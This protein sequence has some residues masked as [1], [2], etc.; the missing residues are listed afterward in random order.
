MI[1]HKR[2]EKIAKSRSLILVTIFMITGIY[3]LVA[4][5]AATN[6]VNLQPENGNI[7]GNAMM[8]NDNSASNNKSLMFG[9]MPTTSVF[10]RND[11]P[12]YKTQPT[13]P[14][15]QLDL[16]KNISGQTPDFS[17]F[18]YNGG[19]PSRN[20]GQFRSICVISHISKDDPI[21][22]PNQPGAAH[23][24]MFYGNTD[25]NAYSTPDS[26]LNSGGS[27]CDGQEANRTSYWFPVMLDSN[28]KTR[29]P[30]NMILYYKNEGINMPAEGFTAIPGGVKM[31]AGNGKAT[32][33]QPHDYNDGF[34]CGGGLF[35]NPTSD[36]I[37]ICSKPNVLS[38]KILFPRCWDGL[39]IDMTSQPFVAHVVYPSGYHS[40]TCDAGHPKVLAEIS[41]LFEWELANGE[42]T[43]GWYL[44]SDITNHSTGAHLPGGTTR[45]GDYMAGW[46]KSVVDSW[47]KDCMNTEWNC[48]TD[49]L[50]NQPNKPINVGGQYASL[51][52]TD[53]DMFD[54]KGPQ[55]LDIPH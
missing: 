28:G 7:I 10:Y 29:L 42:T 24:H 48:Q 54:D 17:F 30:N 14:S 51:K 4:S 45:H 53:F 25:T 37:P 26:I 44:S 5:M 33:P 36:I 16:T 20:G 15:A 47:T 32:S 22:Y 39:P 27:T 12:R 21:V 52:Y 1:K 13:V 55:I 34:A 6:S 8:M 40:G 9:S 50:S 46:N 31:L 3:F 2:L 38:Q 18:K 23:T 35:T 19:D 11:K 49:F 41:I 43:N